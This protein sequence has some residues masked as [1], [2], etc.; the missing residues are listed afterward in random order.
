MAHLDQLQ[1]PPRSSPQHDTNASRDLEQTSDA[2]GRSTLLGIVLSNAMLFT[3]LCVLRFGLLPSLGADDYASTVAI[4]SFFVLPFAMGV[5]AAFFWTRE[6]TSGWLLFLGLPFANTLFA[7]AMAAICFGEG[8]FC[9]LIVSP[10][11][12]IAMV[13]GT[14]AGASLARRRRSGP[15]Q[16][17]LA[18]VAILFGIGDMILDKEYHATVADVVIIDAPPEVVWPLVVE[19]PYVDEEPEYWFFRAGLPMPVGTTVEAHRT[20]ARRQ[21]VFS[22]GAVFDEVMTVYEPNRNLTFDI[23]AQ[24]LDPEIMGHIDMKRGQFILE[25]LGDGRTKLT[26]TS[27]YT[28]HIAPAWYF[29]LWAESIARNVHVRVMEHVRRIAEGEKTASARELSDAGH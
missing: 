17:S 8:V 20:G 6:R 15:L 5:V 19:T 1:E 23:V 24:P 9:L 13:L 10:L 26:G 12:L 2:L 27:W 22:S 21:C 14:G 7:L 11:T 29:D 28:L 25:D 3:A 18:G 16:M 4:T